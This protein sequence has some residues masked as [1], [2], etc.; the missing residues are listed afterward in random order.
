MAVSINRSALSVDFF[1]S[2]T[3]SHRSENAR[4]FLEY[5]PIFPSSPQGSGSHENGRSFK[6]VAMEKNVQTCI[7]H[8]QR[9]GERECFANKR[10][11]RCCSVLFQRSTWSVSP[12]SFP[13][14]VCCSSGI[15]A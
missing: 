6:V 9:F 14:A 11:K 7:M 12:V 2:Q 5:N 3:F 13:T 10:A 8:E 1:I 15:T 4:P